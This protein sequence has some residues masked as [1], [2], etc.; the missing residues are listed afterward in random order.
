V[1]DVRLTFLGTSSA[2]PTLAR[3][4]ASIAV[5]LDGRVLL[6]DCGEGTQHQLLRSHV[7]AGA[8]DAVFITHLH[9]DHLFGLPGL[10]ATL[11]LNGRV[12]PL[13]VFGP[14]GLRPYLESIPYL[15]A[16][17]DIDVVSPPP[18]TMAFD[19]YRVESALLDHRIDCYGFCV[20][21]DDRRGTFDVDRA[22]ALGVPEGP[23]FAALHRGEDVTLDDGRVVRSEDVV[24]PTRRGRRIAYCT[25]TRPCAASVALARNADVLVHESTYA[26]DMAAEA[27]ERGHSTSVEAARIAAEAG[28]ARLLLTHFSPRYVDVAPLVAE[29][30][31][32]FAATDAAADFLTVRV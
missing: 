13:Q 19:G 14:A 1:D 11:G 12:A 32:V 27:G 23:L 31:S 22:R 9:G 5:M 29:A 15:G 6:F 18:R 8:I 24:G 7:R 10:L 2:A 28:C 20:I 17:Y 30:R 21:E 25:D 4:V 26:A 3:N 16:P